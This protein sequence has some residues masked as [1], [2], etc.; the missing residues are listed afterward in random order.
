MPRTVGH[1]SGFVDAHTA[2]GKPVDAHLG[3]ALAAPRPPLVSPVGKKDDESRPAMITPR[4]VGARDVAV[5]FLGRFLPTQPGNE[6][7]Q[8]AVGM[9][10]TGEAE[11]EHT[12]QVRTERRSCWRPSQDPT[13]IAAFVR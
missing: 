7:G 1:A 2:A 3:G 12:P 8:D 13:P 5:D 9:G 10:K 6:G 4:P 11:R